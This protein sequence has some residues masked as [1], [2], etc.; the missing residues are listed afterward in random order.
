GLEDYRG[1]TPLGLCYDTKSDRLLV[2]E[3][4]INAIAVIDVSSRKVAGHIPV[5]WFP[6][7]LAVQDGQVYVAAARGWGTGPSTPGHRIR[8]WGAQ[9]KGKS[10]EVDSSVLRRGIVS[11]F[12]VPDQKELAHLT[13]VV[14]QAN[15][16][17]GAPPHPAE[18]DKSLPAVKHVVLIVK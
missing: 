8:M 7:S 10:Y 5:G 18:P 12:T 14:M 6:T 2:A 4:G 3:A 13:D 15:G 9:G 11:S 17:S 1:I 16:F